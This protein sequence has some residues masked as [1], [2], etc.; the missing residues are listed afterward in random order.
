VHRWSL[1]R[2]ALAVLCA[3][4]LSSTVLLVPA[5]S[6]QTPAPCA[7]PVPSTTQTSPIQYTIADPDCEVNGTTPFVALPGAT[8]YTGIEDGQ[9]YRI[10]VPSNWNG[11]LVVYAHGFRGTGS[12]LWVDSPALRPHLIAQGY[13]WAASSYQTNFYDPEQGVEDSHDMIA[14]FAEKVPGAA[15][16]LGDVIMHGPSMGGHVTAVAVERYPASFDAAY[17]V[18]GVLADNALFDYFLDAN[19]TAAAL[20]GTQ[21][22]YAEYAADP[23]A[24]GRLVNE[25]IVPQLFAQRPTQP[26]PT[27]QAWAGALQQ[28]SGGT[29]P[30]FASSFAYWNAFGFAPLQD[31]PFLFGVYPGLSAG[32]AGVATGNVAGNRD[33]VYQLDADPALSAAERQLNAAVLRVDRDP[34]ARGIPAIAGN[35]SVPVLSLH[36][37]GDLFVPFSMEQVYAQRAQTNGRPFVSRAIRATAH[38]DFTPGELAKGFDDLVRW[39]VTGRPPAGDPVLDRAAVAAGTFGCRFTQGPHA[40]FTASVAC[41]TLSDID[42]SVHATAI[43]SLLAAGVVE[44]FSDGTYGPALPITRGQAA[45]LIA[46]AAGLAPVPGGSRFSDTAGS[47]HEGSIRALADAGVMQG[48]VDGR[49]G[50][51]DFITRGQVASAL[52]RALD[53]DAPRDDCFTDTAGSTHAGRICALADLGV[54]AGFGDGR[55]GPAREVDRAQTATLVSRAFG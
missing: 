5:A 50:L 34:A 20:T 29:R 53:V 22:G 46:R 1:S 33:T 40:N 25:Q 42:S 49:F 52:G 15:A 44:G 51:R 43:R 13:A 18:C 7:A 17:P 27:G 12:T 9:A 41:P 38:C 24:Y 10:E 28:A 32:T 3:G 19:V 54:V 36:G 30:G 31:S 35:P 47:V 6:A 4:V 2:P 21:I 11:D 37:I 55:Y 26:T 8:T 23:A 39:T 48:Y 14:R 16:A 45:S